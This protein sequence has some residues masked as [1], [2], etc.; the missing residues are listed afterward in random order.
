MQNVT[1]RLLQSHSNNSPIACIN[2]IKSHL[3]IETFSNL[4]QDIDLVSQEILIMDTRFR[5]TDQKQ[6]NVFTNILQPV[7][8]STE[9]DIVQAEIHSRKRLEYTKVTILL[10]DIRLMAIFDWWETVRE[11]IF[12]DIENQPSTP[13]HESTA[14]NKSEEIMQFDLK[15]NITDSEIIVVEDASEWDS[16]AVIL[17][18]KFGKR[19]LGY[20]KEWATENFP[21]CFFRLNAK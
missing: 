16:N 6:S 7:R 15:L 4:C 11:Y 2:F 20:Y 1:L 19:V 14:T 12:Q 9:H 18:V 13:E 5:E 21:L 3:T 8:H 17:K 10:N